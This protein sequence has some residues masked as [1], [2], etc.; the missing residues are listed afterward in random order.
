M[1]HLSYLFI[2]G[3][4]SFVSSLSFATE[5]NVVIVRDAGHP[6]SAALQYRLTVDGEYI[7][8]L[9]RNEQ[10]ELT[11][12]AGKH[13]ISANDKQRTQLEITV[14]S[15]GKTVIEGS[16]DKK[17]RLS[18]KQLETPQTVAIRP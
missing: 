7:G 1:K 15:Q 14:P 2:A 6:A 9:K 11:L 10:I 5:A 18:F 8:K 4:L 3:L 12:P 16:I 13:L 17:R